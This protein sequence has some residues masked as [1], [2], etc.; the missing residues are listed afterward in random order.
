ML[1]GFQIRDDQMRGWRPTSVGK[2]SVQIYAGLEN[3]KWHIMV[4]LQTKHLGPVMIERYGHPDP[5]P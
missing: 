5:F 1:A 2:E 3:E 4:T